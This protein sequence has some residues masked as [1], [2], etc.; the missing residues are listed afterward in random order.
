MKTTVRKHVFETNSSSMHSITVSN[1]DL[2]DEDW[3]LTD[4]KEDI[5]KM[6]EEERKEYFVTL[7]HG[8][9]NDDDYDEEDY[10]YGRAPFRILN[11][12]DDKAKY[13]ISSGYL[14]EV[15]NA[16]AEYFGIGGLKINAKKEKDFKYGAIGTDIGYNEEVGM[17]RDFFKTHD[18]TI[19]DFIFE[20]K[21]TVIVDGDEYCI[22][23]G[24]CKNGM[25]SNDIEI[26]PRDFRKEDEY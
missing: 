12:W 23:S 17:L 5:S 18:V 25:I 16:V 1:K 19:K 21:Y 10:R 20:A 14:E 2:K 8:D 3:Y 24:M 15:S 6:T 4:I 26:F 11:D 22:F 7:P 9:Y 13:L